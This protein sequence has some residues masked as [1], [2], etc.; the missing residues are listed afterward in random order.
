MKLCIELGKKELFEYLIDK[1]VVGRQDINYHQLKTIFPE[2]NLASTE[3]AL[4]T[5]R[6]NSLPN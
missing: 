1:K 2:Q 6:V 3:L 4:T 5:F